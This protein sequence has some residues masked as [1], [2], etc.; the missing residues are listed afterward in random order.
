MKTIYY[1]R[2]KIYYSPKARLNHLCKH[3][4]LIIAELGYP[5]IEKYD[6]KLFF[7]LID[8]RYKKCSTIF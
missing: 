7:Q 1:Y 2:H 3:K 6:A 5:P 4:L 8:M